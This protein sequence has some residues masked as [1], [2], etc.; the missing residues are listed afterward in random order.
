[1][2]VVPNPPKFTIIEPPR[3]VLEAEIASLKARAERAEE[4]RWINVVFVGAVCVLALTA[5]AQAALMAWR[6]FHG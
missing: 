6:V 1:M 5:A 4:G 2:F 3:E